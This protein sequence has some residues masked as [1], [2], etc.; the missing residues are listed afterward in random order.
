[1]GSHPLNKKIRLFAEAR[2][3]GRGSRAGVMPGPRWGPPRASVVCLTLSDQNLTKEEVLGECS[4][5]LVDL[6]FV[7]AACKG[8]YDK[9]GKFDMDRDLASNS[10]T[11]IATTTASTT[12]TRQCKRNPAA[13]PPAL[14]LHPLP[15]L[16]KQ[17][18]KT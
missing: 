12:R 1:M 6:S 11:Y 4:Q 13:N 10:R 14:S 9:Q 18:E 7:L 2:K 15:L 3:S 8:V 16:Y 5:T 17:R